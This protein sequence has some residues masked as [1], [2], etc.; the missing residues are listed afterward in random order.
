MKDF[1][2]QVVEARRKLEILN[3]ND[4]EDVTMFVTDIQEM[5]RI[6]DPWEAELETC[7]AGQLLLKKQHF[8]WPADWLYID[9]IEGEWSSF[10]QILQKRIK[11]M[12][13]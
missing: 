7:R 10:K 12:D 11:Q 2:H 9:V 5:K 1:K 6:V 8:H 4:S 3:L 13:D